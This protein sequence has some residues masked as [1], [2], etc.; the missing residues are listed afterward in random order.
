MVVS[1]SSRSQR[2]RKIKEHP[3]KSSGEMN[4]NSRFLPARRYASA[5]LCDSDVSVRLSV[6][7]SHA[8]I[9]T[10]TAKAGS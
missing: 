10:S 5:G 7:P 9:V 4:V 2:K 6:C 8:G 1:S 3:E